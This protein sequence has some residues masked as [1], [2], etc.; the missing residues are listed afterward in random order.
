MAT[1]DREKRK[2]RKMVENKEM[3]R[4]M[5]LINNITQQQKKLQKCNITKINKHKYD[6]IM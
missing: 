5:Q 3:C 4:D 2:Q 6:K 1:K